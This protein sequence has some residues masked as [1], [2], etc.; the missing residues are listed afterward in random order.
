MQT[1]SDNSTKQINS[2]LFALK[3]EMENGVTVTTVAKNEEALT[4]TNKEANA[5]TGNYD[6]TSAMTVYEP[7]QDVNKAASPTFQG[8]NVV[9]QLSANGALIIPSSAS[10]I[11]NSIWI[12]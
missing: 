10:G 3:K 6:G 1:V 5:E 12:E 11:T 4:V 9:G 7:D 2:A 8:A